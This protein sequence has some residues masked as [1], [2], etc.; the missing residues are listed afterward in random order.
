MFHQD[1]ERWFGFLDHGP[2]GGGDLPKVVGRHVRAQS[3]GDPR[4]PVDQEVRHPGRE[5]RGLGPLPIEVLDDIHRFLLDVRQD[6][7][8]NRCQPGFGVSVCGR[9][10]AVDGAEVS[11]PVHQRITK[12]KVLDHPNERVVHSR[13]TMGVILAK[14]VA[15]DGR[16]LLIRPVR[17][18]S[19]LMHGEKDAPVHRLET[20]PNIGKGPLN[21]HA[22][23]VVEEGFSH[24]LLDEPRQDALARLGRHSISR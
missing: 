8:G 19:R 5:N 6:V 3:Y 14:D 16:A 22:H 18:Q 15:H 4:G 24:L 17:P 21:D 2:Q 23:R 11:L 10:V 13:I 1:V 7:L 12:G 20:V 9:G